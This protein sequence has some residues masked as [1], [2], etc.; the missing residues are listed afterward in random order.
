[1]V[2]GDQGYGFDDMTMVYDWAAVGDGCWGSLNYDWGSMNNWGRVDC[3][4]WG[5]VENRGSVD[6]VSGLNDDWGSV[7]Y[8]GSMDSVDNWGGMYCVNNRGAVVDDLAGFRHGG[9]GCQDWDGVDHWGGVDG[10][11]WGSVSD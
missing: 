6:Y 5:R 3:D 11:H 8:R 7:H 4:D 9:L 10:D 1:M 2:D